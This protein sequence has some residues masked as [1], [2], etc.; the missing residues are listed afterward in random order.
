[1]S[2]FTDLSVTPTVSRLDGRAF[3]DIGDRRTVFDGNAR[4]YRRRWIGVVVIVRDSRPFPNFSMQAKHCP[5]IILNIIGG[6]SLVWFGPIADESAP[7]YHSRAGYAH[8]H[9][10]PPSA[11]HEFGFTLDEVNWLGN[12]INLTFLPCAVIVP[13]F[14]THFG[15]RRTVS[16]LAHLEHT[17]TLTASSRPDADTLF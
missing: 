5:Q 17:A 3:V 1:M 12:C 8:A 7:A 10:L 16:I 14:Y 11:V 2:A 13:M 15:L 6:M 9:V 4:V